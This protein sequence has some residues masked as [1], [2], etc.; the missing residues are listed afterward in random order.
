MTYKCLDCGNIF[1]EGEQARWNES[2]GEF[3]GVPCSEEMSGCP[4][5]HG[6]YEETVPCAICGSEHLDDELSGGVCNDCIDTYKHDINMCY[7]IGQKDTEDV[8]LNCF[9]TSIFD[10]ESIE[11]ILFEEL[12]KRNRVMNE[13][14]KI[15]CERFVWSDKSWFAERLIEEVKKNENSKA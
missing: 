10:K 14:L 4:L 1:E 12:K 2:R 6:D 7:K 3:W 15:D 5:C 8:P 11:K 13:F 9:L